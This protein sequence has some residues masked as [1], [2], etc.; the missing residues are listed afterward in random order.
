[1]FSRFEGAEP[2]MGSVGTVEMPDVSCEAEQNEAPARQDLS[3]T[4]LGRNAEMGGETVGPW[5][6]GR[7]YRRS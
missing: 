7:S 1:M 5:P 3:Q 4:G 2:G 6:T